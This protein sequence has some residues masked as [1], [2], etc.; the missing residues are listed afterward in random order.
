[1]E[2]WDTI[3]GETIR[4]EFLSASNDGLALRLPEIYSDIAARIKPNGF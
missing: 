3:K 4:R 2:W 1:V